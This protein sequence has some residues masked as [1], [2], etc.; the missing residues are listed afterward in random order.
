MKKISCMTLPVVLFTMA[1][2]GS[3]SNWFLKGLRGENV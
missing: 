1:A 3:G 2:C